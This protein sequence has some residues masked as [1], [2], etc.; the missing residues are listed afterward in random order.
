MAHSNPYDFSALPYD[1][2]LKL[3]RETSL[4][5]ETSRTLRDALTHGLLA[6][7]GSSLLSELTT[8][9]QD[10]IYTELRTHGR[11]A[12]MLTLSEKGLS[13]R[14]VKSRSLCSDTREQ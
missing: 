7:T 5:A 1:L 8:T 9:E 4:S 12:L 11:L 13:V 10:Q 3:L 6:R 2:A 14:L